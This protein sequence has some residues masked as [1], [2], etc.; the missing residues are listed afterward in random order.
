[1]VGVGASDDDVAGVLLIYVGGHLN[2][3]GVRKTCFV[4]WS[5]PAPLPRSDVSDP[6]TKPFPCQSPNRTTGNKERA[7]KTRRS[8]GAKGPKF[9]HFFAPTKDNHSQTSNLFRSVQCRS[10]GRWVEAK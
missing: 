1:M 10:R 6:P 8:G 9:G 3:V 4:F 2:D 5:P 7:N